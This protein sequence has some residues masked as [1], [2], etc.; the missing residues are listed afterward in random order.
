AASDSNLGQD[1]IGQLFGNHPYLLY[2][3]G[4]LMIGLGIITPLP[5]ITYILLGLVFIF[6]GYTMGRTAEEEVYE[7]VEDLSEAEE[8]RKPENVYE[9]LKID[10]IELE[11]GYG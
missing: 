9:L 2:I 3:M 7:P 6:L 8:L 1:L 10:D 5:S 11:L 4:G